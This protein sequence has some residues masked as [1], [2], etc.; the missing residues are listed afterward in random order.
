MEQVLVNLV[1]NAVDAMPHGGRLIIETANTELSAAYAIR[2]VGMEPGAFVMLAVSDNG[3]GM[4]ADT[5]ARIFEPFFTTKEQGKGTGLGL[6]TVH[7]VINQSGGRVLRFHQA[8]KGPKVQ[9]HRA[10]GGR[11][12]RAN[13]RAS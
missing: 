10:T 6:S 3:Q 5:R 12:K 7:G 9:D 1:V 2:H 13:P 8:G 11:P 4:D